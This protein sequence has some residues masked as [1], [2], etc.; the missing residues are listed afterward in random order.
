M[1]IQFLEWPGYCFILTCDKQG[2]FLP[3]VWQSPQDHQVVEGQQSATTESGIKLPT[4][5]TACRGNYR[6]CVKWHAGTTYT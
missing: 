1:C 4:A 6:L 3:K 2:N 5:M